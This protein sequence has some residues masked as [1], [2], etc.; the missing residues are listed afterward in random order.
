VIHGSKRQANHS[1]ATPLCDRV[2]VWSRESDEVLA[3]VEVKCGKVPGSQTLAQLRGG[4]HLAQAIL[5][6]KYPNIRFR[7]I[8]VHRGN[9]HGLALKIL[10][11]EKVGF[12]GASR[13]ANLV[14]SPTK[15]PVQFASVV[16]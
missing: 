2:I 13:T 6:G 14:K 10:T 1:I 11:N 15:S 4:A 5:S 9:I 16:N 12:R 8:V 7:P 3:V